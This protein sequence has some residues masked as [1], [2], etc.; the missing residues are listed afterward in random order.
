[1]KKKC[2]LTVVFTLLIFLVNPCTGW[3]D[4]CTK[5]ELKQLVEEIQMLIN[6][7]KM[8]A[9]KKAPPIIAIGGC[10]GVGKSTLA[11]LIQA[12]LAEL[13]TNSVVI[14]LDHYGLSQSDRKQLSGELDPRRIQWYKIHQTLTSICQGQT[15]IIKPIINQLTKERG[16]ETL[17]LENIDCVLF[18]GAYT[19]SDL[20]PMNFLEY[21]DLTIYLETSLENI[22]DW[23]WQRELKKAS[24]R[25]SQDFFKHMTE[26][27]NDFAFHVYPTKKNADFLI[28]IDDF[29]HYSVT[30]DFPKTPEPDFTVLRLETLSY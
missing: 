3:A 10:P 16:E 14:G 1:M 15:E 24:P 28:Q 7:E 2:Y 6:K 12:E 20:P 25:P 29:H 9:F 11:H 21:A 5:Q 8:G 19:L 27:V 18:E 4:G 17:H 30:S 23:K 22:Y 26:I 13:N